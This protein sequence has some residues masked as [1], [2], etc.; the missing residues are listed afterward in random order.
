[1][2]R[3]TRTPLSTTLLAT[4]LL[5]AGCSGAATEDEPAVAAPAAAETTDAVEVTTGEETPQGAASTEPGEPAT[6]E[7]LSVEVT[8][9][10]DAKAGVN[11][12]VRTTGFRWAPEHAS[13]DPVDGE[14]HAHLYVDGE[15][16]G[17]LYA[18]WT[19]L[20]LPPGE[21]TIEVTL[22]GNDHEDLVLDG[23]VVRASTTVEVAEPA[24]GH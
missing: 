17:R 10:P 19:H 15:K 7:P 5:A 20:M 4:A 16:V 9:T 21:H 24:G 1:V 14:G 22:N 23:E 3:R 8:A 12:E 13:G 11:V 18:A 6:D 2:P